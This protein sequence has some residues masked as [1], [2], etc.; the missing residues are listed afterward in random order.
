MPSIDT[1]MF[2]D[3][4]WRYVQMA[5]RFLYGLLRRDVPVSPDV[6]NFLLENTTSPQPTIRI[7]SQR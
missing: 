7:T 4:K 3:L 2:A 5:S 6:T 1:D